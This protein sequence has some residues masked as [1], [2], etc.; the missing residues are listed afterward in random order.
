MSPFEAVGIR[1]SGELADDLHG[2]IFIRF[3]DVN[4]FRQRA[5]K[6]GHQRGLQPDRGLSREG[7]VPVKRDIQRTDVDERLET[8]FLRL[9]NEGFDQ[10]A[11]L[12]DSF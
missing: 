6:L 3:K 11:E 12:H 9:A 10:D 8:E 7:G 2:G 1:D 4:R 5:Y